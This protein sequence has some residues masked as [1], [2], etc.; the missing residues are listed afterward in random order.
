MSENAEDLP[1]LASQNLPNFVVNFVAWPTASSFV[2]GFIEGRR[3]LQMRF[4]F[5]LQLANPLEEANLLSSY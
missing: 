2:D 4:P 5:N 1:G 3:L